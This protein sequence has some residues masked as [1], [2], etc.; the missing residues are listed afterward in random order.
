M[1]IDTT[2]WKDLREFKDVDLA[3]SFVLS[4]IVE[5]GSLLVDVDLFLCPEH[6]FYEKPRPAEKACYRPAFLDF[7]RCEEATDSRRLT[8]L[9]DSV[10]KLRPG[11]IHG[12][13]R[14]GEGKYEIN[15]EFGTVAIRADRPM[16]RLKS[17]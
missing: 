17:L 9:A 15:G 3:Q 1:N 10:R 7:P 2:D 6:A 12:F 13:K 11:K 16:I 8:Y 5:S 4:W 14:V